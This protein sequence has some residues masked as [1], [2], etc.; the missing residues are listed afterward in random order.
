MIE[1]YNKIKFGENFVDQMTKKYSVKSKLRRWPLQ[2]FFNILDL[3]II[4]GQILYKETT[5][6][7]IYRKD[8]MFQLA[9]ELS[10]EN[11]IENAAENVKPR[12]KLQESNVQ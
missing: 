12:M 1:L 11:A 7:K 10:T 5:V 4:N 8:F 2:E 3:A 9:N 6:E